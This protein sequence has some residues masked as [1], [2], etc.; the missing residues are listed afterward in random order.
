MEINVQHIE[1]EV[2]FELS[3]SHH[4]A[5]YVGIKNL[6]VKRNPIHKI[7]KMDNRLTSQTYSDIF[8][9][10]ASAKAW[11]ESL[12]LPTSGNRFGTIF[13]N[14]DLL[15]QHH[16]KPTV[17]NVLRDHSKSDLLISLLD[18]G[19]FNIIHQQFS[20]L[21][22]SQLPRRSLRK[23]LFGPLLPHDERADGGSIHARDTLFELELGTRLQARGIKLTSF[24]DIEFEFE[25]THVNVQCK[26]LHSSASIQNNLDKACFQIK[27]RIADTDKRGLVALRIDKVLGTDTNKWTVQD[28]SALLQ[29]TQ[30]RM[31]RFFNQNKHRFDEIL[32]I[33]AVGV[34]V[35]MPYIAQVKEC[36]NLLTR[37]YEAVSYYS[38]SSDA[39]FRK[40]GNKIADST[41]SSYSALPV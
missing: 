34:F 6:K 25:G 27:K 3:G 14:L 31:D 17:D 20:H 23:I 8:T 19:S 9:Q 22:N 5:K 13:T 21:N 7:P 39:F 32:S 12:G 24:D 2:L 28:E 35:D 41:G 36:H 16:N 30:E 33:R 40:F 10:L 15:R 4:L 18:A 29:V 38:S 1:R 37:G 26:R 11:F